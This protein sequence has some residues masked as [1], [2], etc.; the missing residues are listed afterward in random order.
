[1]LANI[2]KTV[3]CLMLIGSNALADSAFGIEYGGEL[4]ESAE[5]TERTGLYRV[6]SPPKPHSLM[7]GYTV[8]YTPETGVCRIRSYSKTF[9]NDKYGTQ[10]KEAYDRLARALNK[11]YGPKGDKWEELQ[12]GALWNEP[13]EF[14]RS[15][16]DGDRNHSRWFQPQA[17][18]NDEFN[19]VQVKI[20]ALD[21]SR[22]YV[23]LIYQNFGLVEKC[24]AILREADDSSL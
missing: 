19:Y 3:V 4:P 20:N 16:I 9:E 22:T 15:L 18:S 23:S 11:K 24:F 10:A 17:G 7:E 14:A 21:S 2:F 6:P 12:S 1:M 8:H 13:D 5:Q